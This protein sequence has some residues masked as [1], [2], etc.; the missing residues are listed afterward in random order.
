MTILVF[1]L[2]T[3]DR[4]VQGRG[5]PTMHRSLADLRS[6]C[7]E[8]EEAGIC[9]ADKWKGGEPLRKRAPIICTSKLPIHRKLPEK[10]KPGSYEMNK[11]WRLH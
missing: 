9:R 1:F 5:T 6:E 2:K 3:L 10:E 8:A 4:L 7:R 11:S